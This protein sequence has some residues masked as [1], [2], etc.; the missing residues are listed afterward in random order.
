[1]SLRP[2]S[3]PFAAVIL[4]G[5]LPV[6]SVQAVGLIAK[7]GCSKRMDGTTTTSVVVNKDTGDITF[8]P[9]TAPYVAGIG[10]CEPD[11]PDAKQRCTLSASTTQINTAGTVTLYAK[12]QSTSLAVPTYVWSSPVGGPALPGNA[13]NSNSITLTF[14]NAGTYTY[15][16]AA[17]NGSGQGPTSTPVTIL[18]ASTATSPVPVPNCIATISPAQIAPGQSAT[19]NVVCNP[20]ATSIEWTVPTNGGLAPTQGTPAGS[21]G[22]MT[23]GV[24]GDFLYKVVGKNAANLPGPISA[25][26]ISVVSTSSCTPVT[27][28][29]ELA[30]PPY[31]MSQ[32]IA[33]TVGHIAAFSFQQNSGYSQMGFYYNT[34]YSPFPD[35]V[36]FAISPC[37][38]DTTSPTGSCIAQMGGQYSAIYVTS[39]PNSGMCLILPNVTYYLN[40]KTNT[41]SAGV[42]GWRMNRGN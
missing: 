34:S 9:I 3:I 6:S 42:C 37:K 24:A 32:D 38:G 33:S 5:L 41:C 2:F 25:A 29:I 1:M 7:D 17:T 27:P 15:T 13:A 20:P 36:T 4:M 21:T 26:G 12:C 30:L 10:S 19:A 39:T 18:V 28:S 22:P 16:V 40:V 8:D 14:P 11:A 23:F 31:S 35:G